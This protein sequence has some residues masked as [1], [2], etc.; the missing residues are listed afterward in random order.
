VALESFTT[1]EFLTVMKGDLVRAGH[2]V[3][4]NRER[5][6][7]LAESHVRFDVEQATAAPGERR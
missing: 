3:M 7:E 1:P 5:F 2:P 6:F 4:K